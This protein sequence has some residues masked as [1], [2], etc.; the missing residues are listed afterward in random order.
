MEHKMLELLLYV[1]FMYMF[2]DYFPMTYFEENTN[3]R[4]EMCVV[5]HKYISYDYVHQI[6]WVAI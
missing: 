4:V 5:L 2:Y 1:S 3:S 6:K